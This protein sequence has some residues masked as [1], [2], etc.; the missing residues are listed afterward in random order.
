MTNDGRDHDDEQ[1][2]EQEQVGAAVTLSKSWS[3]ATAHGPLYT[4]GPIAPCQG[5][6]QDNVW[7]LPVQGDLAFVDA[8]R[9]LVIQTLRQKDHVQD[10]DDEDLDAIVAYAID[11]AVLITCSANHLLRHYSLPSRECK[12]W[13]KSGHTLPVV[14]M[15]LYKGVFLA[16]GSVDGTVR[17]WDVRGAYV[18]HVYRPYHPSGESTSG[19]HG[20]S[21][22]EWNRNHLTLAIGRDDGSIAMHNLK[23]PNHV[24]VLRDH[25]GPVTCL[26]W[27]SDDIF[28]SAGRDA[29][30]H[31]WHAVDEEH[32]KIKKKK[33]QQQDLAPKRTFQRFH[34]KPIYEQVEGMVLLPTNTNTASK[35]LL[36]AT[37]GS[38]GMVRLWSSK[39][40]ETGAYGALECIAE[41]PG[42]QAFGEAK[43]GYLQL[44][45]DPREGQLVVADAEHNLLL[46]SLPQL[47]TLRTI[48]G[49]NDEI[50]D[51]KLVPKEHEDPTHAVVVTN[52]AQV[53]LVE[54]STFSCEILDGHAATVLCV[55]V[56]PCG[57]FI[58]TCGK[59][60]TM[61]LWSASQQQC[62]AVATGHTEAVGATG[63]SQKAGRYDVAGKATVHGGGAFVV[64]ASK[65]R[66]MKR[67]N[68]PG[69]SVL[70][71]LK[72]PIDLEAFRSVRAHEKD[73]NIVRVA[74][75]D[76]LIA[77]GSQDKTVKLWK[78]TDLSVQ[79]TLKGHK[80]GV[81]DC[82][83][84]P[85]DRVVATASGDRTLKLW[86]LSDYSCVRTFQ[87]HAA[88]V[89]RVRFLTGG[90]QLVSSGADGLVK[91][92]T[93]RTNEC[94]AT[95]DGHHD[96]VWALDLSP[97][98]KKLVSGGA[99][100][101]I[102]VWR[103]TTKQEDDTKRQA[104][105]KNILL[106]QRLVNHLRYKE[107]EKALDI[108]L[109]L[110]KPMQ[111]LKVVTSIVENDVQ[112][113]ET[114]LSTL[115]GHVKT[116]PMEKVRQI[117]KY[118]RDWNTR[119]RNSHLAMLIVQA[120]VTN[121]P[122]HTLA[123]TDGLP[124]IFAGITPYAERHF[125]RLDRLYA[126]AYLLDYTLFSM[127]ILDDDGTAQEAYS[128]WEAKSKLVL[129]P[130]AIDGRIQRG[131]AIVIGVSKTTGDDDESDDEVISVGQSDSSDDES[132]KAT[133]D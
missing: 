29:V 103:D 43:G 32:S 36:I 79:A 50:L 26:D 35:D 89:L 9:G 18:T 34:T 42:H 67:W 81:W 14:C 63:L 56:S 49:H 54:L 123:A 125:D 55:D 4:G 60:K 47:T 65:D 73:I 86:S 46:L 66:T 112:K 115:Q 69:S 101:Q 11:N 53:R 6:P 80:R 19:K 33:K 15:A 127:G 110:E 95:M 121:I 2:Q 132:A 8:Q 113:G 117:L 61:R 118:C 114:G 96:R 75:N 59:D 16:T 20:V 74:P 90:L 72:E 97:E 128:D 124:E 91:L 99:D 83:F 51:L 38:K 104:E 27:Y 44:E 100:S 24:I 82:Q 108:A 22:L 28:L 98:G 25:M 17:I 94:E 37:A 116:W 58:A 30:I 21:A 12:Q 10:D 39:A 92:W 76:S 126:D 3:I 84:S 93:I 57:R 105:E 133:D 130:K 78:A 85:F 5:L 109:D 7:I 64:T 1:E 102:L 13:G 52:S 77:S 120:V 68:L 107:F 88:S 111:V 45:Y 70:D 71:A 31:L 87:G 119:A 129:P 41:Q 40:D 131:G 48:V 106:E 23:E 122:A 62:L